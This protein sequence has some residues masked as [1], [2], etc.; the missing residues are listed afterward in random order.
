MG[1]VLRLSVVQ[2]RRRKRERERERESDF[3]HGPACVHKIR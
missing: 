3:V 1:S 2:Q